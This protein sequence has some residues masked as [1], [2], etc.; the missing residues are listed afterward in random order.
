MADLTGK[1]IADTYKGLIKTTDNDVIGASSKKL[2]DGLGNDTALTLG[3][4]GA[5][6]TIDHNL[7]I[8][9]AL[10]AGSTDQLNYPN[11]D[12]ASA[13]MAM[14][15]DAA[16][17]LSLGSVTTAGIAA[18]S[19]SPAATGKPSSI[20]VNSKG[21]VTAANLYT[22]GISAYAS[23]G[24]N[25][26]VWPAGVK[27]VKFT[28]TGSGA[29]GRNATGGAAGTAQGYLSGSVGQTWKVKTAARQTS[30]NTS[31]TASCIL[32]TAA[33]ATNIVQANG[34]CYSFGANVTLNSTGVVHNG[35]LAFS[36][37]FIPGGGGGIDTDGSGS[38]ESEGGSSFWGS[39]PSY[40]AG[41]SHHAKQLI[42]NPGTGYAL[43]EW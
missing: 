32:S 28:L 27:Y 43:L 35:V 36:T 13:G 39:P 16:G 25:N 4:T 40:G 29:L 23:P 6:S 26:F 18:L 37:H 17:N 24:T 12:G 10:V 33:A 11:A 2:T 31:G 20:T 21:Q 34:G 9:G 38:E 3:K 7:T 41:S 5:A 14:I 19:P 42:R 8:G 22:P 15:T 1:I 30:Q